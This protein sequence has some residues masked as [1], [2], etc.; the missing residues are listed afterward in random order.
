MQTTLKLAGLLAVSSTLAGCASPIDL[1]Q[2]TPLSR[3]TAFDPAA[4]PMA[5]VNLVRRGLPPAPAPGP[6]WVSQT[7]SVLS[8]VGFPFGG[9]RASDLAPIETMAAKIRQLSALDTVT[10]TGYADSIGSS[11]EN[12]RVSLRRA[13]FVKALLI[14][15]GVPAEKIR[16]AGA[17]ATDFAVSP[18]TC[19]GNLHQRAVCQAPNRRALIV[20]TGTVRSLVPG[21]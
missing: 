9:V 10:V 11:A 21:R 13:L 3:L 7:A 17:G 8:V 2:F 15:R 14:A 4:R 18:D 16:V 1:S 12:Q 5:A 19:M 20:A 6:V